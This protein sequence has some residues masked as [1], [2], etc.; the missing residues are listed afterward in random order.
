[1]ELNIKELSNGIRIVHQEVTH[2]RLV[3]CGFIL[4]IG[5]RDETKE[6]EGLAHFWEHMAFKGTQK[7]K[8][9]HILNRLESLGGELNAY[10]TKEK[11][12][13]YAS[14]LK[15][16]YGKASELLFDITFNSTFPEKQIEKERQVILEEMAM[17]RDSPDDAIQDELD[18][19]VF[20]N[21]ALGRNIL[22][23]E[24]TVGSFTQQDFF[25]FI[26]TRLDTSRLIFSVVGNISFQKVLKGIETPLSQI[27]TKRSLYV[28][29]GFN[30]YVPKVKT[31]ER[32]ISQSLCA[33]GRPAFSLYDPNRFKLY[34]LNNILGGPS[35]NSRLNLMLREKHGY[36]Y[37]IESSYQPFSDIGFFG[38]YFGTEGKTLKKAQA[39]VLKEMSKLANTRLGTLQLHM[40][41]EQAIGQ[42][43]MA[44]ENYSALMLVYGKSLLD[45]GKVDP[46]DKIFTQIK[47][48]TAAEIQGIAE[49]IFNPDQLTFLTYT[50]Q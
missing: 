4:D 37:S 29:N 41:K 39:L 19:L 3:H 25:D 35:M 32:D 1:M 6:Q 11:V 50:P 43:A 9:F 26:S 5:S 44:E 7:R 28:R 48:T 40:A 47:N 2:T 10:T 18:E 34:L 8:T 31:Q 14:T 21:H 23:T 22:G 16:H 24:Q 17:Y 49:E 12:C 42:M 13:F 20:E 15:E 27:Q 30:N 45:H 36:V 38:I 33:I 46:L